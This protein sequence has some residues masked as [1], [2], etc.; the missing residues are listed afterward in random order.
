MPCEGNFSLYFQI[1]HPFSKLGFYEVK[2]AYLQGD[3]VFCSFLWEEEQLLYWI[4][5]KE[6]QCCGTDKKLGKE[7]NLEKLTI[8]TTSSNWS[9]S[10]WCPF[11]LLTQV[12][13]FFKSN[14]NEPPPPS[15]HQQH[16]P[17]LRH[18]EWNNEF[19]SS[20]RFMITPSKVWLPVFVLKHCQRHNGPEGWVLLTKV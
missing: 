9:A 12:F 17:L 11:F 20:L 2:P 19:R 6:N 3:L 10:S 15:I 18:D 7:D 4:S 16:H 8:S 14:K 5:V 13:L 1:W